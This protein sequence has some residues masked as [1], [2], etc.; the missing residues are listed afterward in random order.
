M[1]S[2]WATNIIWVGLLLLLCTL[3]FGA[4]GHSSPPQRPPGSD[5]ILGERIAKGIAFDGRLWVL[6]TMPTPRDTSGGLVSFQLTD[7]TRVVHFKDGVLDIL[8]ADQ[9][10]WILRK[11]IEDGQF[12]VAAWRGSRFEGLT[13]FHLSTHDTPL[14]LLRSAG[15]LAVLSEQT[16]HYLAKDNTWQVVQLKGKLRSGVGVNVASPNE[17]DGIY[18]GFD[19]GEWGGGLQRVDV[20]TGTVADVERRDTKNLCDGPLNRECDPVTGVIPDPQNRECV[21]ASVGLVHLGMSNGRILR[22]CDSRVTLVSEILIPGDKKTSNNTK[23]GRT[24]AFYGLA[25]SA[26]GGFWGVTYRALYLFDAAG[27]RKQEYPLPKLE[28]VSG[29]HLSKALP[30]VIVLQTDVNWAVSTSGYTP[31]VIPLE[32]SAPQ[33]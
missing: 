11:G 2:R 3:L 10:L 29:I 25:P 28:S 17:G 6:G 31:L 23:W 1:I 12:V 5:P 33:R 20:R 24:E 19:V 9:E 18:V 27:D 30:E 15:A 7:N 8:R 4:D 14:A 22:I 32:S 26:D 13:E 16:V 21:L